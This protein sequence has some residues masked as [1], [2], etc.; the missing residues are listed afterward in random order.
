MSHVSWVL[1]LVC[2]LC[3]VYCV[4]CLGYV[5][6]PKHFSYH[7]RTSLHI[8]KNM[9][10][11]G[12]PGGCRA[13][14]A[15]GS[16]YGQDGWQVC[17]H[18]DVCTPDSFT[19]QPERYS[20][21]F[22]SLPERPRWDEVA[23]TQGVLLRSSSDPHRYGATLPLEP[24]DYGSLNYHMPIFLGR[25][26][27]SEVMQP[28]DPYYDIFI[29][30]LTFNIEDNNLEDFNFLM[31]IVYQPEQTPNDEG[32]RMDKTNLKRNPNPYPNPY[33]STNPNHKISTGK[34]GNEESYVNE[35]VEAFKRTTGYRVH[36]LT[37]TICF[38]PAI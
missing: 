5:C 3:L 27:N 26:K 16:Q 22:A 38:S 35:A 21:P 36:M 12:Y 31:D 8:Y 34:A 37:P 25:N 9:R 19:S 1:C 14:R 13:C 4:L 28:G 33:P 10:Q 17:L 7:L 24:C 20:I 32:E 29:R 30:I 15:A 6:L 18:H 2:V 23:N 11:Q